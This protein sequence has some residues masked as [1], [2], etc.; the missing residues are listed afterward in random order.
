MNDKDGPGEALAAEPSSD[1]GEESVDSLMRR[2]AHVS[3]VDMP[4]QATT[5]MLEAQPAPATELE[6]PPPLPRVGDVLGGRYELTEMLGAGGMGAV[7]AARHRGTG[8]EVAIKVLLPKGGSGK[9][10]QER[11]T[12]FVR[13]ASAAG[14]IRHPNVVDIYDVD[15][16]S[17]TPYIVMERLHGESLWQRIKRGALPA[18]EAVPVLIAAMRGVAEVHRQGVIHRDLKP[19]NIYLARATDGGAPVPKVLDFGVSRIVVHEGSEP[20]PTTLTRAGYILGTPSYMPLEQL[21]GEPSIDVRADVYALGVIL[22]EAL[23]GERPFQA[24]N[25]HEL[26]IRM[27]TETP[28]PLAVKVPH[29]DV[30]LS[31]IVNKALSREAMARFQDVESFASALERWLAGERE[32][33]PAVVAVASAPDIL[34]PV[35]VV[36]S[37]P[38]Q[39]SAPSWP[40]AIALVV[41]AASAALWLMRS[42]AGEARPAS[43]ELKP[44]AV[45]ERPEPEPPDSKADVLPALESPAAPAVEPPPVQPPARITKPRRR[46]RGTPDTAQEKLR[47]DRA[48]KLNPDDF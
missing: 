19:D 35:D 9:H 2:V 7:F 14:R 48:T 43:I 16:N 29:I 6:F 27:V 31:R 12:R 28:T 41:A 45:V 44:P 10:K 26:V 36:A 24:R 8:R 3:T 11:I 17:E 21:R 37:A 1:E 47:E 40:L 42:D 33:E 32:V 5:P 30:S 18:E 34:P 13:E 22:Y 25:D 20:R 23:C 39:R 46:G 15:G 38:R 4:L